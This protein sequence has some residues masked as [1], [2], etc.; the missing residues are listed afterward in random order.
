MTLQL[1]SFVPEHFN[2]NGDQG[3]LDVIRFHLSAQGISFEQAGQSQARKA[4]FLLIGDG[5]R[6][7]IRFYQ[8]GLV[9][10]VPVLVER[11]NSEK[12]TLIVG[13]AYE[14]LAP[15]I[16]LGESTE[17]NRVSD[18]VSEKVNEQDVVGYVNSASSLPD[19]VVRGGFIGTKFFGPLL[20]YNPNLLGLVLEKLG[21]TSAYADGILDS[22]QHFRQK[23]IS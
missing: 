7:A 13:S 16:G 4:D 21:A 15:L 18:F 3:N 10:L 23:I 20:A 5:S 1:V 14:F 9:A 6:A 12:P 22:V 8:P 17:A 11:L 19:I 2:N